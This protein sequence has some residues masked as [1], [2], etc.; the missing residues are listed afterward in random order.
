MLDPVGLW[1][2]AK[3]F[4]LEAKRLYVVARS[5]QKETRA[6]G[7]RLCSLSGLG[8]QGHKAQPFWALKPLGRPESKTE[9]DLLED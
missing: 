3:G 1:D 2:H 5:N 8:E 9:S 4:D 6:S 7:P